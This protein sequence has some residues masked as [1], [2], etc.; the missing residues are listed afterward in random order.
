MGIGFCFDNF[1]S[2]NKRVGDF[3]YSFGYGSD[4]RWIRLRNDGGWKFG[5][6]DIVTCGI[7]PMKRIA[8]LKL[9]G[10]Q[11]GGFI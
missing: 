4:G 7:N 10:I 6:K 9:N 2:G 5:A 11:I 1:Y 8:I 3:E